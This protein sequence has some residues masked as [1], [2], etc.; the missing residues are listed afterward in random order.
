MLYIG[1]KCATNGQFKPLSDNSA[2]FPI[3]NINIA[4][5]SS[6]DLV[7]GFKGHLLA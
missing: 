6:A 2:Q 5:G 7:S 4:C 1:L 3:I